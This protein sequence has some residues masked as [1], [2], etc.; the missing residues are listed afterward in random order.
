MSE[1]PRVSVVVPACHEGEHITGVLDRLFESVRLSCEVLVIV[2]SPDDTTVPA[3]ESVISL[4][5]VLLPL[6]L[7]PTIATN[8][9]GA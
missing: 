3:A 6:P 8:F 5:S 2:D 9:P 4:A 7:A 1:L